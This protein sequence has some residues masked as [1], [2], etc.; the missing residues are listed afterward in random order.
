MWNQSC[1]LEFLCQLGIMFQ[2]VLSKVVVALFCLG[3]C[4]VDGINE[5]SN[6]I[7]SDLQI[8]YADIYAYSMPTTSP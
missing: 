5:C 3:C 8:D 4:C 6:G 7:V 1:W 2:I